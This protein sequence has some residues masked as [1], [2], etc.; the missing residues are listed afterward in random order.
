MAI[1][2]NKMLTKE[3]VHNLMNWSPDGSHLH[4]NKPRHN[5]SGLNMMKR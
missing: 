1:A 3:K 4:K 2:A 5:L